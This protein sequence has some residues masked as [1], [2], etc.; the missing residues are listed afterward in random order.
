MRGEGHIKKISMN[1]LTVFLLTIIFLFIINILIVIISKSFVNESSS[2]YWITHNMGWQK[3]VNFFNETDFDPEKYKSDDECLRKNALDL[4]NCE[5]NN[6]DFENLITD[7][8]ISK[9]NY[10]IMKSN[11]SS[12]NSYYDTN[13]LYAFYITQKEN[14][15]VITF[16]YTSMIVDIKEAESN[17]LGAY[18]TY[19]Y[20][21]I[22]LELIN[23]KW[24][25]VD[26]YRNP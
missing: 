14:K 5:I 21:K 10:E 13:G 3:E 2:D 8:N 16:Q 24:T 22:Y 26:I 4:L 9:E 17:C 11:Y 1:K 7:F 15:A 19:P 12:D 23:D 20:D 25:V 18:K 6:I